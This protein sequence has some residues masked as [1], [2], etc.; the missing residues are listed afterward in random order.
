MRNA[1]VGSVDDLVGYTVEPR[2]YKIPQ[3]AQYFPKGPPTIVVKQTFNILQYEGSRLS[4]TDIVDTAAKDSA[5][6]I[7][8]AHS[9]AR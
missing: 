1:M 4:C 5:S 2:A 3:D 6:R 8:E 9:L 7:P